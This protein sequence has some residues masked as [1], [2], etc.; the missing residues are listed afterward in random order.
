M[1]CRRD[2]ENFVRGFGIEVDGMRHKT[3]WVVIGRYQGK[4]VTLTL[5]KSPSDHRSTKNKI[6]QIR[7]LIAGLE[8]K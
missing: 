6:A 7:R 2:V 1:R 3:H 4:P 5:S 8:N